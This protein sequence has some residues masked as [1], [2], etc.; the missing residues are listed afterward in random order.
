MVNG[1]MIKNIVMGGHSHETLFKHFWENYGFKGVKNEEGTAVTVPVQ[2]MLHTSNQEQLKRF[3]GMVAKD[4]HSI[5]QK[6]MTA[7]E[8]QDYTPL[9]FD[10][11]IL[12]ILKDEAPFLEAIPQEGQQGYKA[13]YQR[14]DSR[15]APIGYTSESDSIDLTGYS[16]KNIGFAKG[17]TDMT[18]Y[19]DKANISDFTQAA[20]EHYMNVQ[21]TTLGQRIALYGQRKEK[22]ILYGDTSQDTGTG[23][24]GD[25]NSFD[26]LAKIFT[27]QG[28]DKDKSGVSDNIVKDI[29]GEI[30]LML[31]NEN[32]SVRDLMVVTS[33]TMFDKITG[34]LQPA[35]TRYSA[36]ETVAD[37]GI[38]QL[39]I[40]GVP[41]LAT[42]NVDNHSD[43]GYTPGSETD[44][45]IVNMR[46]VRFRSLVPL[47]SVPLAR[48]G[49]SQAT[50]IFEFGALIE[51]SGG[52]WGRY[53]KNYGVTVAS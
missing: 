2:R 22:Q 26:G 7:T 3:K 51:R 47:S 8:V 52:N 19:V 6:Q 29:R 23:F 20:A 16:G 43:S 48:L 39:R 41:V 45:F 35:Q 37:V 11:E 36:T 5:S 31:Q 27:D 1:E 30:H 33:Y 15:D 46:A 13:V 17:E 49:L 34:E 9:V 28:N 53:L 32:V 14:I 21:D 25:A 18:I 44:V 4:M 50:A 10:P 38:Q 12:S 24:I 42:H 40:H